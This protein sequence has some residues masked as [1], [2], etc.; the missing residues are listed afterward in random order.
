MKI[1]RFE[2]NPFVLIKHVKDVNVFLFR[3]QVRLL[4][5]DEKLQLLI[6]Q[7]SVLLKDSIIRG[8]IRYRGAHDIEGNSEDYGP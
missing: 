3:K 6:E 7:P 8:I 4:N 1:L 5:L 2:V